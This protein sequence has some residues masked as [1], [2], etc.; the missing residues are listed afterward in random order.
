M[1]HAGRYFSFYIGMPN[2]KVNPNTVFGEITGKFVENYINIYA[3]L[4]TDLSFRCE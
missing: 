2:I 3:Y 4:K 1:Q